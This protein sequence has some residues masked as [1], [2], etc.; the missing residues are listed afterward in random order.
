MRRAR[1]WEAKND[2]IPQ[3]TSPSA[4]QRRNGPRDGFDVRVPEPR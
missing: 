4:W 3:R 2:S 1:V